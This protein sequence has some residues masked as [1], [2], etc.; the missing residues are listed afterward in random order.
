MVK[1]ITQ[2]PTEMLNAC[3]KMPEKR[4]AWHSYALIQCHFD[5]VF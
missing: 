1:S 4:W 5:C 3:Q 2:K